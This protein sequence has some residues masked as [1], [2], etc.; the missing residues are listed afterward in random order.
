LRRLAPRNALGLE[1]HSGVELALE[2]ALEQALGI[3]E[4]GVT[5]RDSGVCYGVGEGI[6]GRAERFVDEELVPPDQVWSNEP[7][8]VRRARGGTGVLE[9]VPR[10]SVPGHF[11]DRGAANGRH[12]LRREDAEG[13]HQPERL[14]GAEQMRETEEP[15]RPQLEPERPAVTALAH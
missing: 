3:R 13:V 9:L 14:H 1:D 4:N 12:A 5:V 11:D 2:D 6:L 7:R 15:P 8:A 10:L